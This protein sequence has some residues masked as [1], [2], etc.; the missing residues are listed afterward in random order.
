[1]AL[2]A[3]LA[4]ENTETENYLNVR[5]AR[6]GKARFSLDF[7]KFSGTTHWIEI[8]S[9]DGVLERY[10]LKLDSREIL[11]VLKMLSLASAIMSMNDTHASGFDIPP[12]AIAPDSDP[13]TLI[14]ANIIHQ[15]TRPLSKTT[16]ALLAIFLTF[17]S[18][19]AVFSLIILVLPYTGRTKRSQWFFK[20]S[21]IPNRRGEKRSSSTMAFI[22]LQINPSRSLNYALH[23]QPLI[24]LG[25]MYLFE[26]L[27]CWIMAH[28][29][30]TLSYSAL[31]SSGRNSKSLANWAPSPPLVN[32]VFVFLPICI[33]AG[34]TG[35]IVRGAA[36][37]EIILG[38]TRKALD[39]LSQGTS[40]WKQL[41]DP[42]Q[43]KDQKEI[44]LSDLAQIQEK[45][46][47]LVEESETNLK[48]AIRYHYWSHVLY[49]VFICITCLVFIFSFWKLT[50]KFLLQGRNSI[51]LPNDSLPC[52]GS[53]DVTNS[54]KE[55]KAQF[56]I[57]R[58]I[59]LGTLRTDRQLFGFTV[60]AY[61]T[62]F[63]M[64]TMMVFYFMSIFRTSDMMI[65]PTWHGVATWMPTVSGSWS[66]VPVAW[67]CWRLYME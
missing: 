20:M 54:Q 25:L 44:L 19:I 2:K 50:Q 33:A 10:C 46:K 56:N 49:L 51:F 37:Y 8:S 21:Y 24:A 60:R 48:S 4:S 64:I 9:L 62:V 22:C 31:E 39:T 34:I 12:S 61:A 7:A 5:I 18:L 29:F 59:Y 26:N 42:F 16:M 66:A 35:V 14:S 45:L 28:C 36:G 6:H 1:M 58:R 17:H 63:S 32:V 30:L 57:T 38:Q 15:F 3:S 67:Q 52:D 43:S 41:Q 13:F 47:K 40:M 53:P 11:Q 23:A 65:N 27:A 55:A